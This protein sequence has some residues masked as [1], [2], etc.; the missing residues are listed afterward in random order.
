MEKNIS[1][2][3]IIIL[4]I[5]LLVVGF[6]VGKM[7]A[8]KP[9]LPKPCPACL[10]DSELVQNW[11]GIAKGKVQ[12]ITDRDVTLILDKETLTISILEGAKIQ[13]SDDQG[14]K[15]AKFSDIAEGDNVEINFLMVTEDNLV[16]SLVTILF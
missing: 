1:L 7:L 9:K 10:L 2:P 4:G 16:G 3:L 13:F 12:A 8:P 14:L 5:I 6:S 15:E 11:T